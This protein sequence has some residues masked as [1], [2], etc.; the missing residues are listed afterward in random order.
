MYCVSLTVTSQILTPKKSV[1]HVF[2]YAIFWP[3]EAGKMYSQNKM[4]MAKDWL[5]YHFGY[6]LIICEWFS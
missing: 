4:K 1:N 6:L 3:L 2:M 5:E